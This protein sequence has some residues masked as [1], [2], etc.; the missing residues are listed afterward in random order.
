MR[1]HGVYRRLA[2]QKDNGVAVTFGH[3]GACLKQPRLPFQPDG[4]RLSH[5]R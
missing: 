3:A 1:A 5:P 2:H 4:N